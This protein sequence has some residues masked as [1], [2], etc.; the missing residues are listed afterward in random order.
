M[1]RP[2]AYYE[3]S[4][5]IVRNAKHEGHFA[6]PAFIDYGQLGDEGTLRGFHF[7]TG[8]GRAENFL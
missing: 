2:A 8:L 6:R 3:G 5:K 7:G 1:L 4:E